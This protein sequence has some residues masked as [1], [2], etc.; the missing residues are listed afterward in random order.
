MRENENENYKNDNNLS[1]SST[2]KYPIS[3]G[4]YNSYL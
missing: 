2:I 1:T 3:N 4:K